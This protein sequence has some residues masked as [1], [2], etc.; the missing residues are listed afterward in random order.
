[1]EVDGRFAAVE[2]CGPVVLEA[3]SVSFRL[4]YGDHELSIELPFEPHIED[5]VLAVLSKGADKGHPDRSATEFV[6]GLVTIVTDLLER[7]PRP[8]SG[9][10]VRYALQIARALGLL[11]PADVLQLREAMTAF[12]E[13]HAP[14]YRRRRSA[15]RGALGSYLR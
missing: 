10:Q 8:P 6:Q 2:H 4:V 5:R 11:L 12:L 14:E 7:A 3:S 15:E 13:E 1:M 9:S